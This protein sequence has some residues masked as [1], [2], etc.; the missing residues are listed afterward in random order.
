MRCWCVSAH[1]HGSFI[2]GSSNIVAGMEAAVNRLLLGKEKPKWENVDFEKR[3]DELQL[4]RFHPAD[5]WPP[6]NAVRE[7]ATKAKAMA[8][9]A[10]A[11]GWN[12]FVAAELKKYERNVCM[13][14]L[15]HMIR[16]DCLTGSSPLASKSMW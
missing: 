11:T 3:M 1:M 2:T 7:L 5:T 10:D 13:W 16:S 14:P 12:P 9:E 4:A 15:V 6:H 8:R